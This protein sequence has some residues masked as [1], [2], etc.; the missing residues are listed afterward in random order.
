MRRRTFVKTCTAL[1][2]L[3]ARS[4][5]LLAGAEARFQPFQRVRLGSPDG[6]ALK[7]GT[8]A[9]EVNYLFHYPYVGT[10]CFLLHLDRPLTEGA[11]LKTAAGEP[12]HWPGGVGP[13]RAIV[14]FSAI[15]THLLT[16]PSKANSFINYEHGTSEIAG[17]AQ[18]IT[19]CAHGSVFD[20]HQGAAVLAG[21]APEPLTSIVLEYDE[22]DDALYALGILGTNRYAEFLKV[23]KRDLRQ[24]F[25]RGAAGREVSG[26]APVYLLT[27]FTAIQIKC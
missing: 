10:P 23:F 3:A 20:P 6:A 18:V 2:A 12:Y 14:A 8:L 4:P 11:E 9:T 13:R 25:G 22:N 27:E 15:C 16:H 26:T 24:Q 5:R 17:R 21:P 19:C 1:L 7:A